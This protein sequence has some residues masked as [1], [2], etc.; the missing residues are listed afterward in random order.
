MRLFSPPVRAM[1]GC[2][3]GMFPIKLYHFTA[4]ELVALL[5]RL[6][7]NVALIMDD[8]VAF[9]L[10]SKLSQLYAL[11]ML[12]NQSQD[13]YL[14]PE[15]RVETQQD[16]ELILQYLMQRCSRVSGWAS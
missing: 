14:S 8:G 15:L 10:N 5:E 6:Q 11:R 7:G 13:G 4:K 12:M 9:A 3:G 1:I 16:R 2:E